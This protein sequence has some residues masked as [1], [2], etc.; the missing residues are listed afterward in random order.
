MCPLR[1]YDART[2]LA[3]KRLYYVVAVERYLALRTFAIAT[4]QLSVHALIAK[5]MAT[6][7]DD[8]IFEPEYVQ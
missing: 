5:H 1:R 2:S 6:P 4:F 8:A 7:A 3:Q